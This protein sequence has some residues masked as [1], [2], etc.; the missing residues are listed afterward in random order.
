M[1]LVDANLLI[2]AYNS[3]GREHEKARPWLEEV[4]SSP[5]PVGL[6]WLSVLAFIRIT[7]TPRLLAR[8]FSLDQKLENLDSYLPENSAICEIR[9]LAVEEEYRYTRISQGLIALLTEYADDQCCELF[10]I[11]CV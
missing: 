8:P 9:L 4:L 10:I 1:I 11:C 6:A 3:G 2:Y 5:E 7:T